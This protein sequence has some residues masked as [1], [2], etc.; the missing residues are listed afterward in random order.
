MTLPA[1]IVAGLSRRLAAHAGLEL[2]AWVVASRA[3]ARIAALGATP[4][5]YLELVSAPRGAAELGVL[6]E[7]VR[8]GETR[9]F[10]H[11]PQVAALVDVVA[12]ALR[13]RGRRPVK[14]WSA[15]CATGEEP[16]TLAVVLARLLP[17]HAVTILA[18]DVSAG[19]L[20]VATA[21][22]YPAAALEHVPEA[23]RD[24]FEVDDEVVRVRPEARR[25]VR[26]ERKNLAD[27]DQPRGF[28]LVWCR[29]VLIYFEAEARRRVVD[30]LVAALD[31][32]GFL[33]VGYS[34]SLRDVA[35]LEP[36]R[37]GDATV[38]VR[39][40]PGAV[41]PATVAGARRTPAAGIAVAA[42]PASAR[43]PAPARAGARR[44]GR[45]AAGGRDDAPAAATPPAA[46]GP[47]AREL[48]VRGRC[49]P[50]RLTADLTA[51]LAAPGCT[52]WRSISTTPSWSPTRSRRSCAAPAPP[53]R[54]P[55]SR[56]R[57][58]RPGPAPGAGCAATASATPGR[59]HE[60]GVSLWDT[61]VAAAV[62]DAALLDDDVAGALGASACGGLAHVAFRLRLSSLLV[63]AEDVGRLALALERGL[64][65]IDGGAVEVAAAAPAV[66]AA[67]ATLRQAIAQ[68]ASPTGR[69]PGRG[70]PST[71][72]APRSTP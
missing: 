23:W 30:R 55:A 35:D 39:R 58:A 16:Y 69:G 13:A 63:S 25:L 32:G 27:D 11:L 10:R 71:T 18:T 67:A 12:P 41:A 53:P 54:P 46:A 43:R 2:P 29:N 57:C 28:D 64:D 48:R 62:H 20:E 5:A 9:L 51:L 50:E 38:Y 37:A 26:F 6:V 3:Q 61:F 44:G 8:V 47:E 31:P 22:T 34:E 36:R 66:I 4:A 60:R 24:G 1:D 14:V 42:T 56:C 68:L 19:A 40:A 33:F 70:L 65:A 45:S 49:D 21:A 7:A 59:R 15:G 17:Q 72:A 52:G